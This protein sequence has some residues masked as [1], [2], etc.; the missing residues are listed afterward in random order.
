[1][2]EGRRR[3][4]RSDEQQRN[5]TIGPKMTEINAR[6]ASQEI[7]SSQFELGRPGLQLPEN[8]C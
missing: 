4:C 5:G 7:G 8:A 6:E 1:M 2:R 3:W